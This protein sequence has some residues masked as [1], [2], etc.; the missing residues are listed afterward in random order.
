MADG[1]LTAEE[2]E[3]VVTAIL[4][5]VAPGEAVSGDAIKEAGLT[6]SDLPP[7]TPVD[8]RTDENGNAVVIT[9]EVA[10]A[11]EILDNPVQLLSEVFSDPGKVLLALSSLGA[12]M[13]PEEREEAEKMV[14]TVVVAGQAVQTAL[15][16]AAAA[17]GAA[18]GGASSGG[19]G[20]SKTPSSPRGGGD[21][22]APTGREDGT[23]RK[24]KT[25]RVRK[26]KIKKATRT[27]RAK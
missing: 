22:G 25:R 2:K 8:V 15:G 11:L 20:G 5:T 10:A 4:A 14:V 17:T 21:A 7:A 27:R 26:T 16:A 12:D 9:A 18:G 19:S 23:R 6:Y 13:S 1:K 3:A 24:P